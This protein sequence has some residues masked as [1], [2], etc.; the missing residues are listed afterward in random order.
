MKLYLTESCEL[1][2]SEEQRELVSL[3]LSESAGKEVPFGIIV[4]IDAIHVGA[5]RNHTFY[6]EKGL[7]SGV[8]SWTK[9]FPKPM[10]QD[11]VTGGPGGMFDSAQIVDAKGRIIG[12]RLE[13]Q[14]GELFEEGSHPGVLRLA[15]FIPGEEDIKKIMDGRYHTVS[16]GVSSEDI[17]CSIC[18]QNITEDYCGHFRGRTYEVETELEKGKT[19][20][21]KRLCVWYINK[22]DANETSFV[23]VPAD[24]AARITGVRTKSK[25]NEDL[26]FIPLSEVYIVSGQEVTATSDVEENKELALRLTEVWHETSKPQSTKEKKGLKKPKVLTVEDLEA[27]SLVGIEESEPIIETAEDTPLTEATDALENTLEGDESETLEVVESSEQE[28]TPASTED[29]LNAVEGLT[30]EK[31]E[32]IITEEAVED[33]QEP[34]LQMRIEELEAQVEIEQSLTLAANTEKEIMK[35]QNERLRSALSRMLS[36]HL[37]DMELAFSLITSFEYDNRLIEITEKVSVNPSEILNTIHTIREE[38]LTTEPKRQENEVLSVKETTD[39]PK[40]SAE[41]ILMAGLK[42]RKAGVRKSR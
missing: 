7:R 24:T 9:P 21:E 6:T 2:I 37:V 35:E 25:G 32:V 26:S 31:P 15:A 14:D 27:L 4:D 22:T 38:I 29:L 34:D 30:T 10:L 41:D 36:E 13:K 20:K 11:H 42:E 33:T 3:E 17:S 8:E 16:I 18:G 40:K 23:N 12:A 5:T 19:K 39:I 28:P 1:A